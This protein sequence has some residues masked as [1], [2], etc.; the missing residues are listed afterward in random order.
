MAKKTTKT[1]DSFTV[2]DFKMWLLGMTEFQDAT[3]VPNAKQWKAVLEKIELL[4]DNVQYV[5]QSISYETQP[6][7]QQH[8]NYPPNA[9]VP[10]VAPQFQ[11]ENYGGA[12]VHPS[13]QRFLGTDDGSQQPQQQQ[14][15][16]GASARRPVSGGTGIMDVDIT[17]SFV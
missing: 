7:P 8:H 6:A 5:Q 4:E 9:P 13:A 14:P 17:K 12:G 11:H 1:K 15:Q 3:W 2:K 10:P 16:G